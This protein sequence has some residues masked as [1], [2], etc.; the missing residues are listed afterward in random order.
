M[1]ALTQCLCA[2]CLLKQKGFIP[3]AACKSGIPWLTAPEKECAHDPAFC[4]EQ[5]RPLEMCSSGRDF[6]N[7]IS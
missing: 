1:F 4:S 7:E 2:S 6:F 3:M 5:P